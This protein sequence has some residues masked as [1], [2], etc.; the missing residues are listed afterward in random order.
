VLALVALCSL[1]QQLGLLLAA[2]SG[3]KIGMTTE[4]L[5]PLRGAQVFF[6]AL[7]DSLFFSNPPHGAVQWT[8]MVLVLVPMT[9]GWIWTR[10]K[11]QQG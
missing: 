5:V 3:Q 2:W 10:P 6:G 4:R 7:L 1:A 9:L 11:P 8:A